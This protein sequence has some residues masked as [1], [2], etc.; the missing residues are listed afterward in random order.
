MTATHETTPQPPT[1]LKQGSFN[2]IVLAGLGVSFVISGDFAG[3]QFGLGSGG[4]GGLFCALLIVAI[5]YMSMCLAL[6]E[7]SAALPSAGG[8]HLFA[9]VAVGDFAGFM[10]AIAILLEY[11]LA[12]AAIATFISSYVESLHI[13]GVP[14]GWPIYLFC[15]IAVVVVHLAGAGEAL[16]AMCA[17]TIIAVAALVLY[18]V[19]MA[20]HVHISAFTDGWSGATESHNPPGTSDHIS[21]FDGGLAGIWATIPFAMWFFLAIEGVPMAAEEAKDPARSVPKAIVVAMMILLVAAITMMVVGPGAAGTGVVAESGNPLVAALEHVGANHTVVV[22]INYA[23][24]LGLVASFFSIIY[25]YSRLTFSLSRAGLL[26]AFLSTTNR[27]G[28]PTWALIVPACV[29]F[30][31]TLVADGD[32][33]MSVAVF[34]AVVSY[35]LMMVAHIVLRVRRPELPRPYRTLGGIATSGVALVLSLGA[36]VATFMNAPMLAGCALGVM[37]LAAVGYA[38]WGPK[39]SPVDIAQERAARQRAGRE[40]NLKARDLAVPSPSP[41]EL[42][43]PTNTPRTLTPLQAEEVY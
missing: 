26:P 29:G 12:P 36:V 33:L 40:R 27:R 32:A 6:A 10:T 19:V 11:V 18:T 30:A 35:A 37:A 13:P 5:L 17:V 7:L 31:L 21:L 41:R 43:T 42:E 28:A 38:A 22:A 9:Q 24:L 16:K 23:A 20:P 1:H 14:A 4:W 3:W 15:Y 39:T 8:G 34:G 25:G 2:W